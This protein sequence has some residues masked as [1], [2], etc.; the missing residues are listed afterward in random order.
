MTL[1]HMCLV[2]VSVHVFAGPGVINT[3]GDHRPSQTRRITRRRPL[4]QGTM[5]QRESNPT[6]G[7]P[8]TPAATVDAR[9]VVG[10]ARAL[11][12]Q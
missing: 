6:G 1:S 4:G 8:P 5:A 2:S 11:V 10:V 12:T 9:A 7:P 3:V